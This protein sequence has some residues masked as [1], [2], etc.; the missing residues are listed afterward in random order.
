MTKAE[1]V[2]A[3][4]SKEATDWFILLQEEPDDA[5]LRA[6]F[7]RWR[8]AEP[9]NATAWAVTEKTTGLMAAVAPLA[10][11]D[12]ADNGRSPA[13]VTGIAT[14]RTPASRR[15]MIGGV[16]SIAACLGFLFLPG[17]LIQLQADFVTSTAEVRTELLQDG[18]EVVLAP[19]SAVQV[20]FGNTERRIDVLRGEAFFTV[21]EPRGRPF[22]VYANGVQTTDIGTAFSVRLVS[23]GA[24]IAVA[25]GKVRVD[26]EA[27]FSEE[28]GE[29]QSIRVRRNGSV[30]RGSQAPN[31]VASWRQRQLIAQDEPMQDIVEQLRP[32][33]EGKIFLTD[34]ALGKRRV[35]GVYNIAEPEN[36]LRGIA[37]ARG[38]VVRQISPW[39]LIVSAD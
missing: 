21:R 16:I 20:M 32:Y 17:L 19:E 31:Q 39:V 25:S 2:Q 36:A 7:E 14:R 28:I 5:P 29:G 11:G 24:A 3:R 10:P 37:Q 18:S 22:R 13:S 8:A 23:D 9:V 6:Q 26:F 30:E 38:A 12:A 33:F 27:S 4:A 34:S 35:T 1:T 15:F